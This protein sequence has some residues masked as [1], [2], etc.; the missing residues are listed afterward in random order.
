MLRELEFNFLCRRYSDSIY[1][2]ACTML[3]NDADAQDA[4]QEVLL[5]IWRSLPTVRL[6]HRRAWVMKLTRNCCLDIIRRRSSRS[7][8]ILQDD[9]SLREHPDDGAAQPGQG[10]DSE[11]LRGRLSAALDKLPELHRSVFILYEVNE[12]RYHEI[13]ETLSMPVNHV[14]VCLWRARKK[15]KNLLT[16]HESCLSHYID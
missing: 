15:L 12:L 5:R 1:R 13:A 6:Y 16:R 2:F 4:T 14:K 8:P 7:F 11:F 9:E 3:R 10:M